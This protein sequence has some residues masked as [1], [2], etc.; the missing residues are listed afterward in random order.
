MYFTIHGFAV[1]R[2][3][4]VDCNG[5]TVYHWYVRTGS[6]VLDYNTAFCGI[7]AAHLRN[8]YTTLQGL[9]AAL[10]RHFNASTVLVDHRQENDLCV[11]RLVHDR[12]VDTA[13]L[14]PQHRGL[15]VLGCGVRWSTTT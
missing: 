11:L 4:V 14:F 1:A 7:T 12:A 15:P 9:Q 2:V 5:A 13:L 8:V 3:S 6:P 10:L